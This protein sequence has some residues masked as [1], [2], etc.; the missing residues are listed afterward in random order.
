MNVRLN[1]AQRDA[2]D[3]AVVDLSEMGVT[4][5]RNQLLADCLRELH[6][7][8]NIFRQ[9]GFAALRADWQALDAY[10]DRAVTLQLPDAQGV[11]GWRRA[12]MKPVP[13]CC[14]ITHVALAHIAVVKSACDWI[15]AH[16]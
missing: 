11:R 9:H 2:V 14:A 4:V 10:A 8:L 7:V 3:Q 15:R 13:F 16:E 12:W 6:R 5:G 1:E